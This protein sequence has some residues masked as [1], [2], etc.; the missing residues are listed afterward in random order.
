MWAF[1]SCGEQGR[2]GY[3]AWASSAVASLVAEYSKG[4]RAQQSSRTG[5][6]ASPH[7]C[8]SQTRDRT[9]V[10][11]TGSQILNHRATRAISVILTF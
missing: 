7:V 10:P 5:L 1:S 6:V 3:G 4:T 8:S 2:L 9:C 11:C